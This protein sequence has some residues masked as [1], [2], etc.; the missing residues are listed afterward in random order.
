MIKILLLFL[1]P[2]IL[3][4]ST[5]FVFAED[6]NDN[7]CIKNCSNLDDEQNSLDPEKPKF[8][9]I[10][11]PDIHIDFSDDSHWDGLSTNSDYWQIRDGEGHFMLYAGNQQLNS[12]TYD[13]LPFLEYEVGEEWILRY[14]I[15]FDNYNQ[16]NNSKWSELLIGL[17]N[18]SENGLNIQWGVGL[19]FLNGANLKFTNLMYGYGT[20]NEWH[21]CPVKGQ[22]NDE[23]SLPGPNQT[24]WV[25]YVKG[26]ETLTVRIFDDENYQNLIEQKTVNG[27]SIDGL[28]FLKI[29]PLVE[30][31]SVNGSLSGRIDDIK[32]Y[33][34]ETTVYQADKAPIPEALEPK[35]MD[36]MLKESLGDDYVEPQS[37]SVY[38][39]PIPPGFEDIVSS[40]STG[41]ISDQ[42]FY[43]ILKP[44]IINEKMLVEEL[45]RAYGQKLDLTYKAQTIKIPTDEKCPSCIKED[46]VHVRWVTPD[47]LPESASAVVNILA[48]SGE[49]TRLTT[50]S[51]SGITYK[52]TSEFSPGLYEI[53]VTYAN[54]KFDISPL[55]LTD[56]E[57][58]KIPFWVK[59]DSLKWANGELP[60]SEFVDSLIF[61]IQNGQLT[62]NYD[63]FVNKES[64]IL[65]TPQEKL[66]E[67]FPTEDEISAISPEVPPPIWEYLVSS[68]ALRLVNMDF[69]SAQKI[70]EDKTRSYDP[71]FGKYDVPFTMIQIYEFDSN[72]MA[73]EFIEEQIWTKNVIVEGTISEDEFS[74]QDYRY[75]RIFENSDMNGTSQTTGDCLYNLTQN[76]STM[77]LDETHFLQCVLED[78]IIQIYV[79]EDYSVVD[80]T[81][82]FEL[83]DI[84]LKKINNMTE[85]QSVKN[86]LALDNVLVPQ[87][88]PSQPSP[89]QPS[90]SKLT[91]ENDPEISGASVGINNFVCKKDDFG[92]ISMSG[93]FV[94]GQNSFEKIKINITIESYDDDI[95]AF[96]SDYVLKLNPHEIRTIDGYAFV[97]EPFHKCHATVDWEKST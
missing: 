12:A 85:I 68:D 53:S 13:L 56:Q 70:L 63:I 39:T 67:L 92:T 62:F 25:E 19:G 23:R 3:L 84:I 21:C 82:S 45:S 7:T 10:I 8:Y 49:N 34:D 59:Y 65:I 46:F 33:N 18:E 47:G 90:P 50:S 2:L 14:K 88:S 95:L 40:W 31:S 79:S 44:L 17:H 35:T 36:E 64:E 69:V 83:M 86:V 4:S 76:S 16:G 11:D 42:E 58:P 37:E 81:F 15:T 52:I 93:Q 6:S 30:D 57:I 61:L 43:S 71:I 28:R 91:D 94:N 89:S 24:L 74:Y 97:D 26:N 51:T 29:S 22:L 9:K 73:K 1:L 60:E 80:K 96:G 77:M 78:K 41:I 87:P 38:T 32:F 27:W 75:N 20:Y 72:E 66:E 54:K 55:L 48:P 5:Q